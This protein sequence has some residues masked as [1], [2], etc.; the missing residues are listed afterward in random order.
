MDQNK[1]SIIT[2]EYVQTLAEI[3]KHIQEAQIKAVISVNKELLKLYWFIGKT[4]AERQVD[5]NWGSNIV[6]QLAQDLQ[7][8]FPGMG[9]FSRTNVFRMKAFFSAYEKIPQAV[10]HI[11]ELPIF[12][13]PW[14]HNVVLLEKVK[15]ISQRLWYANKAIENA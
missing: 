14:G 9:G 10:G 15:D 5:S 6:E 13:I 8:S 2:Q 11:D 12:N 3:K 1:K 4:I 7:D